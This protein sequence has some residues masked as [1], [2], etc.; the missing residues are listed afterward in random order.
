VLSLC[1]DLERSLV[2]VHF[3]LAPLLAI[4]VI[5]LLVMLATLLFVM[6]V[7]L[8]LAILG[9]EEVRSEPAGDKLHGG[10]INTLEVAEAL[11]TSD[12]SIAAIL[13][14][15]AQLQALLHGLCFGAGSW[16]IA[17]G[18]ICV[19][20]DFAA[21]VAH[22]WWGAAEDVGGEARVIFDRKSAGAVALKVAVTVVVPN[23]GRAP[24]RLPALA[25]AGFII[26]SLDA[27][28]FQVVPRHICGEQVLPALPTCTP[29][30]APIQTLELSEEALLHSPA[31]E[32]S[33]VASKQTAEQHMRQEVEAKAAGI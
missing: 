31:N 6:L 8:L 18:N 16:Q 33:R 4:L 32:P 5:P 19:G 1:G 27:R 11:V 12:G 30:F 28:A 20:V 9:A 17:P 14:V 25:Q 13:A 7:M 22:G 2:R 26:V 21:H 15:A 10:D 3:I 29:A 24:C 23:H